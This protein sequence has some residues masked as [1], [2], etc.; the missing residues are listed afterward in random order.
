MSLIQFNSVLYNIKNLNRNKE[1][2]P[3][4]KVQ[5]EVEK[6]E[7]VQRLKKKIEEKKLDRLKTLSSKQTPSQ[8][9][10]AQQYNIY[11]NQR[12]SDFSFESITIQISIF[13]VF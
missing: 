11:S 2:E 6:S 8:S 1:K 4:K 7:S 12:V 13:F 3:L 9:E 5:E 10:T